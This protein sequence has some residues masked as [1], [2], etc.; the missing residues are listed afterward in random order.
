MRDLLGSRDSAFFWWCLPVAVG[1]AGSFLTNNFTLVAGVW[2]VCL[3]WMGAGC[4]LN[5]VRCRRLHC[6]IA[7]P[8]FIL[9]AVGELLSATGM[10]VLGPHS[11]KN[12]AVAALLLALFSFVPETLWGRYL[13]R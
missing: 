10:N 11:A 9:G 5:A 12:I 4:L 6:Y 2:C 8:V 1:L 3:A 13:S 7:G